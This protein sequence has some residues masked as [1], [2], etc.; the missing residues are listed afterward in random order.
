M[1]K[2]FFD[3][4]KSAFDKLNWS[5]DKVKKVVNTY[6]R[7]KN[8]VDF[9]VILTTIAA[10]VT[11]GILYTEKVNAR[12]NPEL[13]FNPNK[14]IE[15]SIGDRTAEQTNT[16]WD[17]FDGLRKQNETIDKILD[18]NC[19][20]D[21]EKE[22]YKEIFAYKPELERIASKYEHIS[23]E[24]LMGIIKAEVEGIKHKRSKYAGAQGQTGLTFSGA[25]AFFWE[26]FHCDNKCNNN[27]KKR[28]AIQLNE[29]LS[30]M[31]KKNIY[32]KRDKGK[33]WKNLKKH[34]KNDIYT[35]K[36]DIDG[37]LLNVNMGALYADYNIDKFKD[38]SLAVAGYNAGETA[39]MKYGGIPP[40]SETINHVKKVDAYRCVFSQL[41]TAKYGRP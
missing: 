35:F 14:S 41:I 20:K 8:V 17:N 18:E 32:V 28:Y 21:W 13:F 39:V 34:F 5:E 1:N 29:I 30:E 15:E 40:F 23:T 31:K 27:I 22:A 37:V 26:L 2:E 16:L 11:T 4:Y 7:P 19:K 9:G 33:T 24:F 3:K 12:N 10:I 6:R 25:Y 38:I 36:W